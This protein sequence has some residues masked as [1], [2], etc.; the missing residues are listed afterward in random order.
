MRPTRHTPLRCGAVAP[1][2][3]AGRLGSRLCSAPVGT[4]ISTG[5][6]A[7]AV[8]LSLVAVSPRNA[9]AQDSSASQSSS[10][11]PSREEQINQLDN[12]IER[13][14]AEAKQVDKV[15]NPKPEPTFDRPHPRLEGLSGDLAE[16]VLDR[17]ATEYTGNAYRDTYVRWHLVKIAMKA[18]QGLLRDSTDRI[19]K[20]IRAM[21]GPLRVELKKEWRD[22]PED[23]AERYWDLWRKTRTTYGYPPFERR[24]HGEEALQHMTPERREKMKPVVERMKKLDKKFERVYIPE[25]QAYND[26]V[27]KVN[28]LVRQYRG[29]LIYT[30]L[31]TGDPSV[32]ERTVTEID[33]RVEKKDRAAFDILSFV[34]LAA[35]D[36][37]FHR[38]EPE[39]LRKT[40]QAL[41]KIGRSAEE[42]VKY[43]NGE[44]ELPQWA[45]RKQRNFADYV[46][47]LVRMFQ[48]GYSTFIPPAITRGGADR[49]S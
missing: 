18:P 32:L 6:T 9:T 19:L 28:W 36:G 17:M 2:T 30:L 15:D 1:R 37:V 43:Q 10:S 7:L 4:R 40:G 35:L 16:V 33:N 8:L 23:I 38:Y 29:E 13:L 41:E 11:G 44:F 27:R 12:A 47:H 49:E 26:R 24:A 42:Y 39:H 46:F 21:P 31:L 25:L 3:G 34:Y 20:L 14:V 48:D 5:A 22:K 45:P